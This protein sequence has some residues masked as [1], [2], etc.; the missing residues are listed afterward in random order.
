MNI[1]TERLIL[2]PFTF[3]DTEKVYQM[4]LE[5]GM[6]KWIPDQV[7]KDENEAHEVLEFLISCYEDP[8]PKTKPFVLGIE[9]KDSKELIGHVGLS[10]FENS[11]EI[12]YAVEN[13]HQGKG[14]ATEAI[15]A[16]CQYALDKFNLHKILGIV[17][18]ENKGSIKALE[19][20][21]FKFVEE[22]ERQAF[23][24]TGLCRVYNFTL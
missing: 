16:M 8:D 17:A 3:S 11:V 6:K 19:K 22:K 5:E 7:Y 15:K 18:S 2:R 9:L 4:S 24:R 20:A 21:G 1:N 23:G 10:P 13:K 12:G 14:Y